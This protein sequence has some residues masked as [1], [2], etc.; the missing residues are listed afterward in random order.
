MSPV[1]P[2]TTLLLAEAAC[3]SYLLIVSSSS[4]LWSSSPH[5]LLALL[6]SCSQSLSLAAQ[7]LTHVRLTHPLLSLALRDP[8][9]TLSYLSL[10]FRHLLASRRAPSS[11]PFFA[12]KYFSM[13]GTAG[14]A[15]GTNL[16]VA[17][18]RV[19]F[20]FGCESISAS[21]LWIFVLVAPQPN[22]F[23]FHFIISVFLFI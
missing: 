18:T 7:S 19:T 22:Y 16:G 8:I 2:G 3:S 14:E 10:L 11:L 15:G 9:F 6:L 1:A 21:P 13:F 23:A 17:V 20:I 12:A 5:V 4:S